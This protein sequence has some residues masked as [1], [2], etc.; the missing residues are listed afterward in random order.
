MKS[1]LELPINIIKGLHREMKE[2]HLPMGQI[3]RWRRNVWRSRISFEELLSSFVIRIRAHGSKEIPKASPLVGVNRAIS[4]QH[5]NSLLGTRHIAAIFVMH[6]GRG[7]RD[8]D[9][10]LRG[11]RAHLVA[12]S[13]AKK[14][15]QAATVTSGWRR[16]CQRRRRLRRRCLAGQR[17]VRR[18]I[19]KHADRTDPGHTSS[20]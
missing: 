12:G 1:N 14:G 13:P 4:R 3:W 8:D 16:G 2:R 19:C 15:G 11:N 17:E 6:A 7:F 5:R 18:I 20:T 9:A 10:T